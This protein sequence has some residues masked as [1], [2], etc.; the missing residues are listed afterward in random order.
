MLRS[1]SSVPSGLGLSMDIMDSTPVIIEAAINGATRRSE[2]PHVPRTPDEIAADALACMDAGAAIIH[3]HIDGTGRTGE[4]AA[5][6]YLEG[7]HAVLAKRP[8]ALLYPTVNFGPR[9]EVAYDHIAPLAASGLLRMGLSDPGSVNL[10]RATEDGL[11]AGAWVYAN[12]YDD[13]GMQLELCHRF[14]VGPSLAI[15]EPGF[16][17]VVVAYWRAGRLPRGAMVKLYLCSERG[18]TGFPFG[19]PPTPTALDAYLEMLEGCPVPWAVSVVGGDVV[20]SGMAEAAVRQGGHIHLGLEFFRGDRTPT[21]VELVT[22]A[23]E[24]LRSLGRR[25]ATPDDAAAILGL[26]SR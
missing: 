17:R 23:V 1:I 4:D 19:L 22:E 16:L 24:L 15:Y 21:N 10:G 3:N 26:E 20:A 8:D 6:R 2:N 25:P 7:W 13:I 14:G 12:S 11:P 9:L 5:A 18:L